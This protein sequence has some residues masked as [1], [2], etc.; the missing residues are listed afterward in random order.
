MEGTEQISDLRLTVC[1]ESTPKTPFLACHGAVDDIDG[2]HKPPAEYVIPEDSLIYTHPVAPD[3]WVFTDGLGRVSLTNDQVGDVRE[4]KILAMFYWPWHISYDDGTEAF[5]LQEFIEK[6]PEAQNDVSYSGWNDEAIYYWN[7][8]IYGYYATTDEWVLRRQAEL[9][10]NAGVDVVFSDNSNGVYCHRNGYTPVLKAW[11]K[12]LESGVK[13]PKLSFC[14]PFWEDRSDGTGMAMRTVDQLEFLYLD[15]FREGKYQDMW[16]YYEGKPMM[17]GDGNFLNAK[18]PLQAEIINFFTFRKS[19][20]MYVDNRSDDV[21]YSTW[22]W[23]AVSPQPYYY[24][25]SLEKRKGNVE[26]ISVSV[27]VNYDYL[28]DDLAPMNGQS[29]VGRSYTTDYESRYLDSVSG[30]NTTLSDTSL[31]GYH[32]AEQFEYALEIDPKVVFVTGW[33]EW[34][35]SRHTEIWKDVENSFADQFN[36]EFSRDIEPSKGA[37]KDHYYYQLVN[38]ARRFKGAAPIPAPSE[39]K[40]IDMSQ[41]QEQWKTVQ[42]YFAAYIGNTEDRDS[43]G[44]ADVNRY[45][46]RSGRNDIIGAQVARDGEYLYFNVECAEDITPYTDNLWMNLYIDVDAESAGWESF[47]FVLNK[48]KPTADVAVLERFTGEGYA[49]EKVADV[50]YKLDGRY[51]TVK[52]AKANLGLSGEE[53]TVNFLWTDNVHDENDTGAEA[54]GELIYSAFSGDILDFYTS[55]DVAPGARFKYSYVVKETVAPPTVEDTTAPESDTT[56][57]EQES[58]EASTTVAEVTEATAEES[59]ADGTT[60]I[61][62]QSEGCKSML[63][64]ATAVSALAIICAAGVMIKKRRLT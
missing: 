54:D 46:D 17:M 20:N 19:Y 33:N 55:G 53:Y 1:F 61:V 31:Y 37:L 36:D 24:K 59:V 50:E 2:T 43:V 12:A 64:T 34:T 10:A 9:I 49:S 48:T 30:K 52:I 4:D 63:G 27:A 57:A 47:D 13:A 56:A 51:L 15:I 7:E 45:V 11:S 26:Q 28:K 14:L 23:S 58:T 6:Y 18:I 29:I 41:G 60:A 8:P 39:E 3:T 62:A 40:S 5:N 16:F 21:K 44:R 32:F 22:A 42:P 25:D 38:F 35:V